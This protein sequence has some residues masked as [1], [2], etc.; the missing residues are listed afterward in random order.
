MSSFSSNDPYLLTRKEIK[1]TL[2]VI[3]KWYTFLYSRLSFINRSILNVCKHAWKILKLYWKWH[4]G[5]IFY[6][7]GEIKGIY[8]GTKSRHSKIED[9]Y[10]N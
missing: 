2:H 7:H 1:S 5:T 8:F 4:D 10:T 6:R 9:K 3:A